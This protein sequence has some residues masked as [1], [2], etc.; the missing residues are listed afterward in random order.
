M[1]AGNVK[2]SARSPAGRAQMVRTSRRRCRYCLEATV[3][4]RP[5]L[6]PH[7]RLAAIIAGSDDA[8]LA[9][10]LAGMITDWNPAAERLYGYSAQEAI[11]R[12]VAMLVPPER[13][14]EDQRILDRILRGE[15]IERFETERVRADG[16]R[17]RVLL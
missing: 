17:V 7:D 16:S 4:G 14:G 13:A 1:R 11:G 15:R 3:S 6:P 9:K 12:P 8:I 5:E 10:D 2:K